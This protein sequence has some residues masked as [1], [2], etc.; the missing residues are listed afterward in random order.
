MDKILTL[1]AGARGFVARLNSRQELPP[2]VLPGSRVELT[3]IYASQ[4]SLDHGS[5]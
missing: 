1:Q 2:D 4:N 5:T 3:G